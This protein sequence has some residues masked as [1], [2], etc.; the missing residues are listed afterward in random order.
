M[1]IWRKSGKV[2]WK[3][4]EILLNLGMRPFLIF[5]SEENQNRLY[6]L[7]FYWKIAHVKIIK[8]QVF[9][10][11]FSHKFMWIVTNFQGTSS[12]ENSHPNLFRKVLFPQEYDQGDV[13]SPNFNLFGLFRKVIWSD[14]CRVLTHFFMRK[15]KSKFKFN[16]WSSLMTKA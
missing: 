14:M 3:I 10:G 11:L 15:S 1:I 8:A 9:W 6:W 13:I 16:P 2:L 12:N 5:K 4:R 7:I